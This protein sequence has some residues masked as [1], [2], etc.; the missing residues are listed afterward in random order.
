M[1]N[2]DVFPQKGRIVFVDRQMNAQTGA[3][4]IAAAFPN[5]GQRP[6]SRPVRTHQG[7]DRDSHHNALLIPQA[8]VQELQGLQQIYVAGADNKAHLTTVELGPQVGTS[9]LVL[10]GVAPGAKVITDNLQKLAEGAP[11]SPARRL[12]QVAPTATVEPSAGR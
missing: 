6:A 2:G 1:A 9:W 11:V 8:S 4:R 10:D 7:R 12:P 5:P 3:I